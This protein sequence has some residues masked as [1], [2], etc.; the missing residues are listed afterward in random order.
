MV[1][2]RFY[3]V[4]ICHCFHNITSDVPTEAAIRKRKSI[5]VRNQ[6]PSPRLASFVTAYRVFHNTVHKMYISAVIKNLAKRK[7]ILDV[8]PQSKS[9]LDRCSSGYDNNV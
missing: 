4:T 5:P 7:S 3:Q 2:D 9:P 8:W 1:I 6:S